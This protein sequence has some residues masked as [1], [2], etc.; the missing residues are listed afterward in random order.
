MEPSAHCGQRGYLEMGVF[1]CSG[2]AAC[3][4]EGSEVTGTLCRAYHWLYLKWWLRAPGP[5]PE[6]LFIT[7]VKAGGNHALAVDRT[8]GECQALWGPAHLPFRGT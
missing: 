8:A 6:G 2:R 4:E 5:D 7:D 3:G 1:I